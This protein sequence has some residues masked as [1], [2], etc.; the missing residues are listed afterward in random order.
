[1]AVKKISEEVQIPEGVQ[2]E[3]IGNKIKMKKNE[4]EVE[5][6]LSYTAKQQDNKIMVVCEKPTKRDKRLIK[7]SVAHIRNLINGLEEKF[8]YKLQICSVHFP[9]GVAVQGDILVIKNFPQKKTS[10]L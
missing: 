8:V 4:E 7:T 9:M 1:M 10:V 5:K 6:N 2:V 3:I